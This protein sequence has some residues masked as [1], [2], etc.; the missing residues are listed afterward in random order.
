ME[1][2][3]GK[4]WRWSKECD[5]VA[6]QITYYY[7]YNYGCILLT[8][9]CH[10]SEGLTRGWDWDKH[11]VDHAVEEDKEK[12]GSIRKKQKQSDVWDSFEDMGQNL[13]YIYYYRKAA[14]QCRQSP[15]GRVGRLDL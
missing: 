10:N 5:Q 13:L 12:E 2:V 3:S 1:G 8:A 7:L 14:E 11:S 15:L 4:G 6:V 9:V